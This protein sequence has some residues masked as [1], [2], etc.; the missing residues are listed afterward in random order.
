MRAILRTTALSTSAPCAEPQ[1][2]WRN[3]A[4]PN[5]GTATDE[6]QLIRRAQQGD[7]A[8]FAEIYER[9]HAAVFRY[10][11]YRVTDQAVAEELTGDVFVRMVAGMHHFTDIG[12]PIDLRW[13]RG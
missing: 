4:A 1:K 11:F 12:R 13:C 7:D 3:G 8:A 2:P 6:P 10:I 9:H 5:M